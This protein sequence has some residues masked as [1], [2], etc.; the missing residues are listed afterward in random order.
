M[1][2]AVA[3]RA[4]RNLVGVPRVIA[5]TRCIAVVDQ[6]VRGAP[7]RWYSATEPLLL[8]RSAVHVLTIFARPI[9]RPAR[10]VSKP[11]IIYR[12]HHTGPLNAPENRIASPKCRDPLAAQRRGSPK[13][14]SSNSGSARVPS[15]ATEC[16]SSGPRPSKCRIVGATCVVSTRS[17]FVRPADRRE[18]RRSRDRDGCRRERCRRALRPC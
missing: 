8:R 9:K 11:A 12:R 5:S 7:V 13:V 16:S 1:A 18:A 14:A 4:S 2:S 3:N 17:S 10:E 15:I 6:L